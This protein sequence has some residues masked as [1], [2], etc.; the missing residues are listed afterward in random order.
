MIGVLAGWQFYNIS[1]NL[2]YLLPI[3]QGINQA[4]EELDCS[5]LFGCGMGADSGLENPNHPAW[6]QFAPDCDFAP[7][8]ERNTD[9][10]I[11]FTP[12]HSSGRS[13]YIRRLM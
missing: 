10:L 9:G 13:G 6:P 2:N 8:G 11:V 4:A 1:T 5:V 12:L 7:I 3:Y